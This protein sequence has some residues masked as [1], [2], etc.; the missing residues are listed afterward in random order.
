[1]LSFGRIKLTAQCYIRGRGRAPAGS[2]MTVAAG[3]VGKDPT[4]TH[5]GKSRAS[6]GDMMAILIWRPWAF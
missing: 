3:G 1:M 2:Q 4:G 6:G 5:L